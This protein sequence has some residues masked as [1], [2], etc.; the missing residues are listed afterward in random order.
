MKCKVP[1]CP[2]KM[3]E[4]GFSGNV[5]LPCANLA[6][7]L[8]EHGKMQSKTCFMEGVIDYIGE[9]TVKVLQ[10]AHLLPLMEK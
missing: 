8:H 10:E 1:A 7:D 5:C 6:Q 2:N 9:N 4:G 3:S